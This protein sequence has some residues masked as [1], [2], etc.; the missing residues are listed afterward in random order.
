[1]TDTTPTPSASVRPLGGLTYRLRQ[2]QL[3]LAV[4]FVAMI[5][6][7][8]FFAGLGV[9]VSP[10]YFA[11]HVSLGHLFSL[12][13]FGL[14][15]LGILGRSGWTSLGLS[16]ALFFLYGLQYA[17][18]E[19][20]EGFVRAFHALNALVLFWLAL[21]LARLIW[22]KVRVAAPVRATPSRSFGRSFA[23]VVLVV[24]GAVLL[25]GAFFD[26]IF[27]GSPSLP[28][29]LPGSSDEAAEPA[30]ERSPEASADLYAQTCAACHGETGEGGFGPALAGNA[31]LE[32]APQVIAQVLAGGGGMPA[33]A[34]LSD[35]K[36][37]A[38]VSYVRSSWGNRFPPVTPEEVAA[39]R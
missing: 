13:I 34:H 19:G 1:M 16:A 27:D 26:G 5:G 12:P 3:A 30:T 9:L 15:L 20:T 14:F 32:D 11:W 2:L 38:L 18:L 7:Q 39:Q 10:R 17:F 33:F 8:V 6:L 31:A 22:R 24:L 25:F 4:L 29:A 21:S 35:E 23:G 28:V 36:V 37:A